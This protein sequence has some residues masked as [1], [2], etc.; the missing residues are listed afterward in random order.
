MRKLSTPLAMKRKYVIISKKI[1]KNA[2]KLFKRCATYLLLRGMF[3]AEKM[4]IPLPN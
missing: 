4:A 3:F 1:N 2:A